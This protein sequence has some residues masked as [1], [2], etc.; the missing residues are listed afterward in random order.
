MAKSHR[1]TKPLLEAEVHL[2][3][4]VARGAVSADLDGRQIS[5]DRGIPG[6]TVRVLI[7]RRHRPW[8]GV[9][10]EILAGSPLRQSP[11]CRYYLDDCGG[12]Q[13]QHLTYEAQLAAKR[14]LV[15]RELQR[16][17]LDRQVD[18]VHGMVDP[19][20]YRRTAAI[21][22]GWEAGFRPRG[23]RGIVE[24]RDCLI[25]HPLIGRLADQ[26]NDLLRDGQL[27]NYHGKV[28][29]DCTVIGTELD[30]SIQVLLQG[31]MGLTLESHPELPQVASD[32][33]AIPEV[34]AVA[35]RHRAGH[36]LPLCGE[37][38]GAIEV[39]GRSLHLPA[40]SFFQ[41]NLRLLPAV[42][43][44]MRAALG[45]HQVRQAADV[46]GGVGTFAFALADQVEEMSLVEL[47][48]AAVD[49]AR[50]TATALGVKNM[51]SV[52]Q[53]AERAVANLPTLDLIVV[54][55]PR[56]GLGDAVVEAITARA[57]PL[58]FYLSCAPA[59]LARD[60]SA[61]AVGGYAIRSLEV[62]DFYPQTY[63]VESL[64]ILGL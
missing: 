46:Y 11:P 55:P 36:A 43:A 35:F 49:A 8:R 2:D 23:R 31:I 13:W 51:R 61:L 32:L 63:H 44:R 37:L 29:L 41:T 40:G 38:V 42:I 12:C 52:S 21:A 27:P 22:I 10:V 33:I 5:I 30:P 19:W 15:N 53:H 47:D 62:F 58:V 64:A 50:I 24:I 1:A 34:S 48:A 3:D 9:A 4:W 17:G 14:D 25:A 39:D 20:R 45:G 16:A 57:V 59:S 18:A 7:D 6:E 54:D 60:L 26:L 28:W 56:S